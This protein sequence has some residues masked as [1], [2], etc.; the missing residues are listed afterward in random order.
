MNTATDT[1]KDQQ[2]FQFALNAAGMVTWEWDL[3]SDKSI[4]SD[5][6]E[7]IFGIKMPKARAYFETI[8][9]EDRSKVDKD[10][11]AALSGLK[12][13]DFV[14]R[15]VLPNGHIKWVADKAEIFRDADGK[16]T[17]LAGVTIDITEQKESEAALRRSEERFRAVFEQTT[18]GIAQVD[19]Q[20]RFVL[21]NDHY[22]Q[23]VGRTR[24]ELSALRMQEITDP[25]D[26]RSNMP[27]FHRC[28]SEGIPFTIEKRY[29][30]PDGGRVWV[31]NTV[32]LI[33]SA[34]GKPEYVQAVT[35]DI[36]HRKEAEAALRESEERYRR[37]FEVN[38]Q[39]MWV[40]DLETLKF[41][42]VNNAAIAHYGY[43]QAEFLSMT[44]ED[45]RPAE[46]IDRVRSAI[47]ALPCGF[48]NAGEWR[49]K[50][51]DGSLI[52][53]EISSHSLNF[54]GRKA[55]L[56]LARDITIR[57]RTEAKLRENEARMAAALSVAQLGTF[58]WN[59]KTNEVILDDRSREIFGFGTHEGTS[60]SEVF[61]RIAPA[62]LSRVQKEV[63]SSLKNRS[64]LKTDYQ[65]KLPGGVV[66]T[67][68]SINHFPLDENGEAEWAIGVFGDITSQREAE[69][70]LRHRSEQFET[71]L[72]R[73]PI[74][75]FL[76]D[77]GFRIVQ[78]NPVAAPAFSN[79]YP[80]VG[81]D[82]EEVT[83]IMWPEPEAD[84]FVRIFRHT[85][86]TGEPHHTPE[87]AAVRA[88]RGVTEYYNWRVDRITLPDGEYGVVCYFMDISAEVNARK[89]LAK[90]E[91]RYRTLFNSIDEGFCVLEI[92]FDPE[93]RAIDY[94]F[95]ETNPA[96]EQQ[97]GLR[98]A[99]G[100]TAK[101]LLPD[102][103][104]HWFETYGEVAKTGEATRFINHAKAMNRWFD[105]YAFRLEDDQRR[106]VALL[107]S[108]ISKRKQAEEALAKAQEELKQ[109]AVI[110]EQTVQERTAKLRETIGELEHFSYTIT[111]DMRAPLR[112]MQAFG[113]ILKDEY[114]PQLDD[115]GRDYLRRITT[116]AARMDSL[117]TDAL[118]YSK[119]V[120][121]E[122]TLEP[123]APEPLLREI[124]ESY[125][126]F[127]ERKEQIH[128]I[129]AF[130][131]VYGNKAALTQCFSNLLDNAIKFVPT[132]RAPS[133]KV[134]AEPRGTFVR[135]WF[136]D[137]GIGIPEEQLDRVFGM[138][139]QLNTNYQGTG[140]GL[141]LVR[142]VVHRM[143]GQVGVV[144][145]PNEGSRFWLDL[146][147]A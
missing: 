107:F 95:I 115:I 18:V 144:S 88:D 53:V 58:E 11:Q 46:D 110:L 89:T 4:R 65:I 32:S 122:L 84:Y 78:L 7:E 118:N 66:R 57:K 93:E 19:Q 38:P 87:L 81:R 14:Y 83:R 40:Y 6:A 13:Y 139:Q 69:K 124:L 136:E 54:L 44:L 42:A 105:V 51:K 117:I 120:Q 126:Q 92:I 97:T 131:R 45:I 20:G 147:K 30:R 86:E 64:R 68:V 27:L 24:E 77:S 23:I 106:R 121:M 43:T 10:V 129:S 82:L 52:D 75:V 109:H 25:E 21:A 56:A 33:R 39:P 15:I 37:L 116:A 108:D 127:H 48:K 2:R 1:P 9:P 140:I 123:V 16:A 132:G 111:H 114:A 143:Q 85:L 55:I 47:M 90:S 73:A 26:V 80:L 35:V 112:A 142:K 31:N 101:E 119:A 113:G 104:A 5:N 134:W 28:V 17:R 59:L 60:A 103:E 49:H 72:N 61:E 62:D 96:F 138:F 67:V 29:I 128:L 98:N 8:H 125:P 146:K 135:L 100:R 130:P 141:A 41:L 94:R 145:K 79:I 12:P 137:N 133:I 36:S 63:E 74:G 102:L 3:A 91:E 76:V 34:E 22:C 70:L 99:T 50:K 71:L